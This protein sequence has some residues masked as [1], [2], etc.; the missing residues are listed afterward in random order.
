MRPDA[1]EPR[2]GRGRTRQRGHAATPVDVARAA[3]NSTSPRVSSMNASSSDAWSGVSSTTRIRCSRATSAI[4]SEVRPLTSSTSGSGLVTDTAR[5]GQELGQSRRLVCPNA[6]EIPGGSPDD[7]VDARVGDQ[8]A[9]VRS[10]SGGRRSAPSRSSGETRRTPSAPRRRE[11]F[12]RF[13]I[14]WIPSGSSPFTG[15]S[16]SNVDGSP[17]SAA[18]IPSRCPIPSE[19]WPARFLRHRMQPHEVDELVHPALA[20]PVRLRKRQ[21]MVVGGPPAVHGP[22]LEH[23]A[24]LVQRRPELPIALAVDGHGRP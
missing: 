24:D 5:P 3:P 13:R 6:N 10:R 20:D 18:A 1:L 17:S 2:D 12:R 8:A 22:G 19:N 23:R 11:P 9:R 16:S 14:Q 21:Q 15:S 7:V 4:C